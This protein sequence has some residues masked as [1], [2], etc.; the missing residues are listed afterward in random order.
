MNRIILLL[1]MLISPLF[2]KAQFVKV[3][4]EIGATYQSMTQ[5]IYGNKYTTDYQMG[6]QVGAVVDI[7]L[8][9]NFYLQTGLHYKSHVGGLGSFDDHFSTAAGLPTSTHDKRTYALNTLHLPL[10]AVYKTGEEF[11][12]SKFFVGFGPYLDF[13]MN[14]NF[15][16]EYT[17]ALNG[18]GITKKS[19]D[20]MK[21]GTGHQNDYK[22]VNF[23]FELMT[24]YEFS[25]GLYIKGFYGAG[26]LNM[27]PVGNYSNKFMNHG[28][29]LT[30]GFLIPTTD[31]WY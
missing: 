6:M 2:L 18:V 11:D 19:D 25:F 16:R 7:E 21:F 24:G 1:A 26:I 27:N 20:M 12:D 23:G 17:H 30:L 13:H 14:G 31:R 29:G 9:T 3:G 10:Y 4:P 8:H 15:K 5:K 22:R 28:G